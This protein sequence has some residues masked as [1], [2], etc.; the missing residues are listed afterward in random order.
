MWSQ[1]NFIENTYKKLEILHQLKK[2]SRHEF[3]IQIDGGVNIENAKKLIK[4]GANVLVAGSSVF[5]SKDPQKKI[6]DLKNI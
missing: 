4:K 1:Q 2:E 5:K 6:S 3:L